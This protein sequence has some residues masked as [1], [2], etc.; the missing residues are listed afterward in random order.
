MRSY[1]FILPII[2]L[3]ACGVPA[4]Q[5]NGLAAVAT[6]FDMPMD[7]GLIRC[8]QLSNPTALDAATQWSMGQARAA[9]LAGRSSAAPDEA[10]LSASLAAYCGSHQSATLRTASAQIGGILN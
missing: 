9:V 8:G 5:S 4:P 6:P 7:P 3:S 10:S 2:A 1:L